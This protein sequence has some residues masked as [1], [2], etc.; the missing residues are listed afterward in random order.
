[1]LS[2]MVLSFLI[3]FTIK[4][5]RLRNAIPVRVRNLDMSVLRFRD[6]S[7]A[8]LAVGIQLVN[9]WA[10][11]PYNFAHLNA[12]LF[13]YVFYHIFY[14]RF[15][16]LSAAA[17]L[18]KYIEY[19]Q[20]VVIAS[21]SLKVEYQVTEGA[22]IIDLDTANRLEIVMGSQS[23]DELHSLYGVLK[24][25]R[26]KG[27]SR[28]L[29]ANLLQPPSEVEKI[30]KRLDCVTELIQN[31]ILF[32]AIEVSLCGSDFVYHACGFPLKSQ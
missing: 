20:N 6:L 17:A 22:T 31:P 7:R 1:M 19:T 16:A 15:Y 30:D 5:S 11:R 10:E 12:K 18:L 8:G 26:S 24:H 25:C 9:E 4:A 32:N 23:R 28:L 21:R 29:R 13:F 14:Y 27:G 3:T 2:N